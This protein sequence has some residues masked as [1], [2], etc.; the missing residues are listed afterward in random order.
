MNDGLGVWLR[1]TRESRQL[2]LEDVEH[3]LKIR[4]RYLQALEM[5]DYAALP[6]EIQARGFLRNYARFLGLPVDDALERYDSEIQGRP[7]QP[8]VHPKKVEVARRQIADRPSVFAPPP[9]EAEEAASVSSGF[10]IEQA[11][12][13]LLVLFGVLVVIFVV[14]F[15]WL[16]FGVRDSAP[17]TVAP[18]VMVQTSLPLPGEME[19]DPVVATPAFP[20][21]ADGTINVRLVASEHVWVSLATAERIVFQDIADPGQTL[22]ASS[23]STIIVATGN[24]GAFQLYINGTDWGTLGEQGQAVRRVWSPEGE[25]AVE[26]P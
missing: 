13:V 16:Q 7:A 6:G 12:T 2:L 10:S 14:S 4:R 25:I 23:Q 1:R 24:G 5:G 15:L 8:R 9:S 21:S 20:A 18:L 11:M 22:E 26:G 19:A 17:P 3:A